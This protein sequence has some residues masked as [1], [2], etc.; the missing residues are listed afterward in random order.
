MDL[1][2]NKT[3]LKVA[4]FKYLLLFVFSISTMAP[5]V[6]QGN[7]L[8]Y[9]TRI[10]FDGKKNIKKVF[11]TNT[12]SKKA[13]YNIS[14]VEYKM[15]KNGEMKVVL[16]PEEGLKFASSNLRFFPRKVI[17]E[18]YQSQTLKVQLRNTKNLVEGEYRSHLYF[19]AVEDEGDLQDVSKKKDTVNIS[20][21]LKP[22][23]GIS[24][25]CIFRIGEN[26][27]VVS[28]SDLELKTVNFEERILKFNL[29]RIGNMSIYGDLS[30]NYIDK[31]NKVLKVGQIN[32]VGVY[33][34]GNL[35]IIRIKL[36]SSK[37]MNFDEGK[38][39]IVFTK[40]K[41][42]EILSEASLKL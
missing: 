17:L 1:C 7:L 38:L 22:I 15:T 14:F 21:K 26:T 23:F 32:G 5:I 24:I 33:T 36:K 27:T 37:N 8:V 41:S 2:V 39:H 9:P 35:R 16:L 6:A 30:I 20:V 34:P 29:N 18:P 19:R 12:G 11:L 28:L 10:V 40:N 25:P 42:D 13:I 4:V 3:F 31:N